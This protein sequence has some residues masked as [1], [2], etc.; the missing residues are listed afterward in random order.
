MVRIGHLTNVAS[1]GLIFVSLA[2]VI[3]FCDVS[4]TSLLFPL[5]NLCGWTCVHLVGYQKSSS[6]TP[7][8]VSSLSSESIPRFTWTP[9][10]EGRATIETTT[11]WFPVRPGPSHI[12]YFYQ[13][14]LCNTPNCS[15]CMV[16]EAWRLW[17][18]KSVLQRPWIQD[19]TLSE[20]ALYSRPLQFKNTLQ[21]PQLTN[22]TTGTYSNMLTFQ[23]FLKPVNIQKMYSA[24]SW[25][26]PKDK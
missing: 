23:H 6:V 7:I 9:F 5:M 18:V 19:S 24:F 8:K 11:G 20:W 1:A 10:W 12:T 22:C 13:P 26:H 17:G 4:D 25:T 2:C 16:D 15:Y 14:S 3:S 21:A